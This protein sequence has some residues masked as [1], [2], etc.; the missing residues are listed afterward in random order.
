V[1][2]ALERMRGLAN[3]GDAVHA[4]AANTLG[5]KKRHNQDWFNENN[6]IISYLVEQ[7]RAAFL[8]QWVTQIP[9]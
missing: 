7:K 5:Y 6:G 4:T 9:S 1:D 3:P 8:K 2:V